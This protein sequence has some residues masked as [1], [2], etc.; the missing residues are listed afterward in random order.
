MQRDVADLKVAADRARQQERVTDYAV[1]EHGRYD[2][3]QRVPGGGQRQQ[4]H[5]NRRRRPA[6]GRRHAEHVDGGVRHGAREQRLVVIR[7]GQVLGE[8]VVPGKIVR[9]TCRQME[10]DGHDTNNHCYAIKPR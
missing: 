9:R 2:H 7:I 6:D 8:Q 3:L 1:G 10:G 5:E 4:R